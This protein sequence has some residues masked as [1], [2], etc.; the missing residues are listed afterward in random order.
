MSDDA[1]RDKY[2]DLAAPVL[3]LLRARRIE[4]LVR[5]LEEGGS[6]VPLLDAVLQP[7]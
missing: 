1:L 7:A 6:I 2:F 4:Q 3:G 5:G